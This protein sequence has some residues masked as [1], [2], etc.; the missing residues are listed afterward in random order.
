MKKTAEIDAAV[1]KKRRLIDLL[2]EQ[3]AI[4]INRAVT[5]GLNPTAPMKDSGVDW[6]GEI[7][8]HWDVK[9]LPWVVR[10]QEGPGIM[11]VDFKEE[12]VPLL[13]ISSIKSSTATLDGCNFLS[14]L[15]VKIKWDHFRVQKGDLL[16]SGSASS[17]LSS[18]VGDECVGA[19]PYTGIFRIQSRT[20]SLLKEF[21]KLYFASRQ[22]S[23]QI[24]LLQTGV[25]LQHFGPSH[26][27]R[28][29]I[30]L[31]PVDEQFQIDEHVMLEHQKRDDVI[32]ATE[33]EIDI[34]HE[35][36]QTLIA[37][38]VTGKIKI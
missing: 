9:R 10:Y 31:P 16:I 25:G 27:S 5:K 19:V 22:F 29:S 35:F 26:L 32:A 6:I 34:L 7:P 18:E 2:N 33:R 37:N 17:G 1:G 28:V 15:K 4:L 8:A 11:A 23:D 14:P 30:A 3:K 36:K 13:R 12:G 24:Q 38:A 21:L 20:S